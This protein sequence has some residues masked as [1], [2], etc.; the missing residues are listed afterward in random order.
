MSN[1][2]NNLNHVVDGRMY[3]DRQTSY[4][5]V[6]I[7]AGNPRWETVEGN[8]KISLIKVYKILNFQNF[9]YFI[10]Q[11]LMLADKKAHHPDLNISHDTVTI[12][13]YTN[14]VNDVTEIDIEM[15]R[16]IDEIYEDIYFIESLK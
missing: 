7:S 8:Q 4:E 10:N 12:S 1:Q 6:P 5:E 9:L 2:E 14:D 3:L 16:E 11:I 15:S 13:L